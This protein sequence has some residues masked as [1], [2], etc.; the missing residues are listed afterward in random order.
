MSITGFLA[1]SQRVALPLG[2]VLAVA[3]AGSALAQDKTGDAE[4]QHGN[5]CERMAERL[6]QLDRNLTPDQVRDIVAGK[7][8]QSGW[9]TLKVGKVRTTKDGVVALDITTTSGSLVSTRE[10]SLKTGLPA[11]LLQRCEAAKARWQASGDKGHDGHG[12]MMMRGHFGHGGFMR[13][14]G[15]FGAFAL[16]SDG[17]MGRDLNLTTDQVRKLADASLI[18][19]GNPR[20]KVGAVKEKDANTMTVDIVTQDNAL[21]VRQEVDRHS[22]RMSRG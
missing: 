14:H 22:G 21:V 15:G 16:I 11:D 12:G 1:R 17:G 7:L 18:R 13:G 20:L 8:A 10:I 5:R 19:V 4:Q 9:N 2:T 3:V 6:N